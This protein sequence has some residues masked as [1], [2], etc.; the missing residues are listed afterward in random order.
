MV[1]HDC[2]NHTTKNLKLSKPPTHTRVPTSISKEQ[3]DGLC[4]YTPQI[5]VR[6]I[7][8]G[9]ERGTENV[10]HRLHHGPRETAVYPDPDVNKEDHQ[11]M[12]H[13]SSRLMKS[14]RPIGVSKESWRKVTETQTIACQDMMTKRKQE[15][16]ERSL[17]VG[18]SPGSAGYSAG[19]PA[20]T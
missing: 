9:F 5:T 1:H 14:R 3:E 2:P 18:M 11:V 12:L 20:S 16:K 4:N 15:Q 19:F 17:D 8:K 6:G 10:F 13:M 7:H